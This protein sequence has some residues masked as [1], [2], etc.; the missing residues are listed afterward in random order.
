M[1]IQDCERYEGSLL[2]DSQE[3][4]NELFNL[5]KEWTDLTMAVFGRHQKP[6]AARFAEE[7]TM[8]DI[9]MVINELCNEYEARIMG[10]NGSLSSLMSFT[11]MVESWRIKFDSTQ[12]GSTR[13]SEFDWLKLFHQFP[14]WINLME[15]ALEMPDSADTL[16]TRLNKLPPIRLR[17]E[18]INQSLH[19]WLRGVIE[20]IENVNVN[21]I[22]E[23]HNLH[24]QLTRWMV[25]M[26][27]HLVPDP[28]GAISGN[29]FNNLSSTSILLKLEEEASKV[30]PQMDAYT[31]NMYNWC[32]DI[33]EAI[34]KERMVMHDEIPDHELKEL[35]KMK[36]ERTNW[37][38]NCELLLSDVKSDPVQ[39]LPTGSA[40]EETFI[41]NTMLDKCGPC[42]M[43]LDSLNNLPSREPGNVDITMEVESSEGTSITNLSSHDPRILELLKPGIRSSVV[44]SMEDP[45]LEQFLSELSE[46]ESNQLTEMLVE[47]ADVLQTQ[48]SEIV[49]DAGHS[50]E[51]ASGS[52][53][54]SVDTVR[55]IG[56]DDNIHAKDLTDV[57][58]PVVQ[59]G[60]MVVRPENSK[61]KHIFQSLAVVEI[62]QGQLLEAE[63][64]A[65]LAEQGM[66]GLD[67]Q[68]RSAL[69]QIKDMTVEIE[70]KAETPSPTSELSVE[71]PTAESSK[72]LKS[73]VKMSRSKSKTTKPAKQVLKTLKKP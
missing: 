57:L 44:A 8:D 14:T 72:Q 41:P 63:K 42:I 46:K 3:A 39:L 1:I 60:T 73:S 38:R 4:L 5:E 48:I 35:E 36:V 45:N 40:Q 43:R 2:L 32:S 59:G 25:D 23:V 7:K 21:Q 54:P 9:N 20:L 10:K 51:A 66:L 53:Q 27:L 22:T 6:Y 26:L 12:R 65:Q 71:V 29:H 67:E 13:L 61:S 62:L 37:I 55:Y 52:F 19:I 30:A 33:V 69:E 68:L 47:T 18:E 28:A 31:T 16:R 17:L 11:T 56:L 58:V 24:T 15:Q 34:F 70:S 49:E 50:T 64:R